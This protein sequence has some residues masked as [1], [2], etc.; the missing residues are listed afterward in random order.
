M[1]VAGAMTVQAQYDEQCSTLPLLVVAGNGPSLL[2][3][4]W[5]QSGLQLDWK[6][7]SL[8]TLDKCQQVLQQNYWEIHVFGE[9][10]SG[11][12][13]PLLGMS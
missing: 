12:H 4:D 10:G 2:G 11:H 6:R 3:R 1:A 9:L 8:T 13:V 5:L 7:I